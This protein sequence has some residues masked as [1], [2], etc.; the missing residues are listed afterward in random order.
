ML[1][2]WPKVVTDID[3]Y[4]R[5]AILFEKNLLSRHPEVDQRLLKQEIWLGLKKSYF[6]T[7]YNSLSSSSRTDLKPVA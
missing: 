5:S 2:L 3:R 6:R 1:H 4:Q 7:S